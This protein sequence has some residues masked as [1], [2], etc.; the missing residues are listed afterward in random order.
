MRIVIIIHFTS[1]KTATGTGL[2]VEFNAQVGSANSRVLSGWNET[3]M[4]QREIH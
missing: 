4:I 3:E 2:E 1:I